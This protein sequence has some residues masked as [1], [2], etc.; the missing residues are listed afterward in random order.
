MDSIRSD[1]TQFGFRDVHKTFKKR[2][3]TYSY[4]HE[5]IIIGTEAE[6]EAILD[7]LLQDSDEK[8]CCGDGR[9]GENRSCPSCV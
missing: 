5:E 8:I 6:K 7:M 4:V 9:V 1:H 3:E 2:E